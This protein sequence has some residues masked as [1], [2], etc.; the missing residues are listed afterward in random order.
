[1]AIG[2]LWNYADR[3]SAVNRLARPLPAG[4]ISASQPAAT[5]GIMAL[6]LVVAVF[7]LTQHVT[8][9]RRS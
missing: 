6:G 2:W 4:L 3:E 7:P 9:S 5:H 1:M 8:P